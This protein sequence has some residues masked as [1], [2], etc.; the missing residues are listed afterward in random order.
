MNKIL[1]TAL[2]LSGLSMSATA[3]QSWIEQAAGQRAVIRFGEFGDNLREVSPGRL[4]KFG[5]PTATLVSGKF[6]K[7]AGGSKTGSGFARPFAAG[8]GEANVAEV[9]HH[10]RTPG[11][12]LGANGAEPYDGVNYVTTLSYVKPDGI[13]PIP[14]G[15]AAAPGK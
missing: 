13:A 10:E 3:H 9:S 7:I 8:K 5:K 2:F 11:E 6:E 4:D 12:R 1:T 15:P 14:A